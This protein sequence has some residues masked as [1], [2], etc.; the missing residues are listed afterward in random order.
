M[1]TTT[2]AENTYES[3]AP[4]PSDNLGDSYFNARLYGKKKFNREV[5]F[6]FI[7][8]ARMIDG[9]FSSITAYHQRHGN[10]VGLSLPG[11]SKEGISVL[12][13]ILAR[14]HSI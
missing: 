13:A 12:E 10:L 11:V 4:A 14:P 6:G 3:H 5:I 7:G 2:L 9:N 1:L 8:E